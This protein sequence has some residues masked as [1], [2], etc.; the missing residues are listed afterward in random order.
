L[1]EAARRI[2]AG[3]AVGVGEGHQ[4][5]GVADIERAVEHRHAERVVQ[6]VEEHVAG[7]GDAVAVGIAQQGNP[8]RAVAEGRGPAHGGRHRI[9]ED[10]TDAARHRKRLRGQHVAIGQD[11][12]PARMLEA[13][14][15]GVDLQARSGDGGPSGVPAARRRHLER[16]DGALRTRR[17]DR[18]TVAEGLREHA[19]AAV[20]DPDHDAADQGDEFGDEGGGHRV[21]PSEL[22]PGLRTSA[23]ELE[24]ARPRKR[25]GRPA[26]GRFGQARFCLSRAIRLRQ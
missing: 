22:Y 24:L 26:P 23:A 6:A 10:R 4:R 12:D 3:V 2:D 20:A 8:V 14:G 9:V 19:L 5:V 13:G 11:V 18:R 16:R 1:K 7:L 25:R 21:C 15:E 17:R